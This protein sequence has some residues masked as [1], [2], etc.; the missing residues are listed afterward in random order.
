MNTK[1]KQ[2]QPD[3]WNIKEDKVREHQYIECYSVLQ[4]DVKI[5]KCAFL[6]RKQNKLMF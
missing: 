5:D 2:P 4:T 3:T 6:A 1:T